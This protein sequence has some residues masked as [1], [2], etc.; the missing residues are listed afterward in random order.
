MVEASRI[1]GSIHHITSSTLIAL[2]PK[3]LEADSFKD[4]RPI[5][6]CNITFKIITKIIAER[7]KATLSSFLSKDQH[8]FLKGRNIMDAVAI[9]QESLFS[10]LSNRSEGAILKIDLQR[11]YDCVDWGLIRCLLAKIG[12]KSKVINWIMACIENVNYVVIINRIPTP[13]FSIERGLRQ[14]CPL[15]PLL[16]IL[17]MESLSLHINKAVSKKTCKLMRICM[18]NIISHNL[19]VNDVLIFAMLCKVTW[20]C[21]N[22]ILYRFQRATDLQINKSKSILYHKDANMEGVEWI[23]ALFG[24]GLRSIKDG[25]KYLG[26]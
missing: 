6:L 17:V 16:L 15:S 12:L 14:G 1:S 8:A 26:F 19:F 25:V 20:T 22:D 3:K 5:S 2:I 10:M 9:T 11:A 24:V 4:F 18:N 23:S 7:I 21:L 13:F